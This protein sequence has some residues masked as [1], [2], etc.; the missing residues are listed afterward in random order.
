M[1]TDENEATQLSRFPFFLYPCKSVFHPW[2]I[3]SRSIQYR[4]I[5]SVIVR[6]SI[7][8]A[9]RPN[10][11]ARQRLAVRRRDKTHSRDFRSDP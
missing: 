1:D 2:L 4:Q 7:A 6:P 3:L 10:S 5:I 8:A 9:A 11:A